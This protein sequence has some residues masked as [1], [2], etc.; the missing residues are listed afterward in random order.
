MVSA[1]TVADRRASQL[2]FAGLLSQRPLV[3]GRLGLALRRLNA[4]LSA[5]AL[6][7]GRR[8]L[9]LGVQA[10][11]ALTLWAAVSLGYTLLTGASHS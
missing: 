6:P 8:R 7:P 9:R 3:G 5:T 1:S 4:G 11:L 10:V 2:Y